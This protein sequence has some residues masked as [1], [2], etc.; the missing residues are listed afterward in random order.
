[1]VV[2]LGGHVQNGRKNMFSSGTRVLKGV[3]GEGECAFAR[4]VPVRGI[5]RRL[6]GIT[7]PLPEYVAPGGFGS[8]SQSS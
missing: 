1:V 4:D 8:V 7:N 6:D 5:H 3:R 2:R